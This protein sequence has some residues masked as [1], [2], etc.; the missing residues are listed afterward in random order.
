MTENAKYDKIILLTMPVF[1]RR[2]AESGGTAKGK[3]NEA[4]DSVIPG[5]EKAA[6]DF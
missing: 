4:E 1:R 6:A 2:K 5:F 3:K